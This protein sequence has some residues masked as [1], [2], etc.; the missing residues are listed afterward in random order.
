[1]DSHRII[2]K[3]KN[4]C[5]IMKKIF[6]RFFIIIYI[7]VLFFCIFA[8]VESW[9]F[10]DYRLF[11]G[12]SYPQNITIYV[13]YFE[14][15]DGQYFNPGTKKIFLNID[16]DYFDESFQMSQNDDLKRYMKGLVHS[17][18]VKD[19][20]NKMTKHNLHPIKFVVM[21]VTFK[22]ENDKKWVPVYSPEIKLDI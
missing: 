21:K 12:S 18:R 2:V 8:R 5:F 15:L 13:P 3:G 10:S 17:A 9:P 6:N 22:R 19:V 4:N 7:G 14:L 16:R 20:I 11:A 1:M